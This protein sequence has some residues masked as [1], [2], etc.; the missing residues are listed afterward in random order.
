MSTSFIDS[1]FVR[2][3]SPR[4]RQYMLRVPTSITSLSKVDRFS[5]LH[6]FRRLTKLLAGA[7]RHTTPM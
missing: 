1:R 7:G 6:S 4:S 5:Q 2:A 3:K